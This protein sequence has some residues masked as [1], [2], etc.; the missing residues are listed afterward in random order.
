MLAAMRG[1]ITWYSSALEI[2]LC[3]DEELAVAHDLLFSLVC[4]KPDVEAETDDIDVRGRAPGCPCV[5][6]VGIT[7]C[8]GD[9]GEFFVLENIADDATD[10]EFSSDGEFSDAVGV[11]IGMG[12][13]P[14]V[15][16]QL[17]VL[18]F[19]AHDA[20]LANFNREWSAGKQAIAGAEPVAYN[21]IDHEGAFTF[22]GGRETPPAGQVP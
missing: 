11:F 12:V 7:K 10:A 9:A 18:A 14:E 19:A 17:L 13:G 21:S 6:A 3:S 20:V 15:G 8:N 16:F 4:L 1:C 2:M 5:L 22:A